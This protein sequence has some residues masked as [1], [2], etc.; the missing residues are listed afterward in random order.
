MLYI[1]RAN[2]TEHQVHVGTHL[3]RVQPL[4]FRPLGSASCRVQMR[5]HVDF[6]FRRLV[7]LFSRYSSKLFGHK[8]L[9]G[10]SRR[11]DHKKRQQGE[12]KNH[13]QTFAVHVY[14]KSFRNVA[15]AARH[16]RQRLHSF[17]INARQRHRRVLFVQVS[18]RGRARLQRGSP[19]YFKSRQGSPRRN[20]V[21][22]VEAR[23]ANMAA[24]S[25]HVVERRDAAL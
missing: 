9:T 1:E 19:R 17:G 13:S 2:L 10:K 16:R 14:L 18:K 8:R 25:H 21:E 6:R 7:C 5:V 24:N 11:A 15:R 12:G 22:R 4:F 3:H 23:Y 20:K